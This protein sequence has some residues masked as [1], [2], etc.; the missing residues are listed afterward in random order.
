MSHI[1]PR[2][3]FFTYIFMFS[4]TQ[5]FCFGDTFFLSTLALALLACIF[6]T[7][8]LQCNTARERAT[9]KLHILV[10]LPYFS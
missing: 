1:P 9:M 8:H 10:E 7:S 6:T 3:S 5:N 4:V 2:T